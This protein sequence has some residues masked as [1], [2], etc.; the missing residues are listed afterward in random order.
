MMVIQRMECNLV[1]NHRRDLKSQVWFQTNIAHLHDTK[2]N[3]HF[4]TSILNRAILSPL[5]NILHPVAGLLRNSG[6]GK[7]FTCHLACIKSRMSCDENSFKHNTGTI[8]KVRTKTAYFK[9]LKAQFQS[10]VS[11]RKGLAF[12]CGCRWGFLLSLEKEC[13]ELKVHPL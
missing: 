13:Q 8:L 1:G 3:C 4:I 10:S 7:A 12:F 5:D 6:T 11:M 2:L 9:V